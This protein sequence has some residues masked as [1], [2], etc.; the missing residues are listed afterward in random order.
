MRCPAKYL[1]QS[2][3]VTHITSLKILYIS[4]GLPYRRKFSC[5]LSRGRW[6][7]WRKL[8]FTLPISEPLISY[9]IT[10]QIRYG[11]TCNW[12]WVN[13]WPNHTFFGSFRR[14]IRSTRLVSKTRTIARLK[15]PKIRLSITPPSFICLVI[16]CNRSNSLNVTT[17][18]R[19][20]E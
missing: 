13:K 15:W 11:R 6:R 19:L 20:S 2:R 9:N 7:L 17:C 4:P 3:N 18:H 8:Y 16:Y 10:S 14:H 1:C 5:K 12:T